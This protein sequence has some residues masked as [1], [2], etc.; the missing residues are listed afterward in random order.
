MSLISP[1]VF[2]ILDTLVTEANNTS[3]TTKEISYLRQALYVATSTLRQI[4]FS[5][6]SFN[7]EIKETNNDN[8]ISTTSPQTN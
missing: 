1:E 8:A 7:F 3:F 4:E 6:K 2:K 5:S